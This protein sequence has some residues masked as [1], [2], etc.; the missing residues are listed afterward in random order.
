MKTP[1]RLAVVNYETLREFLSA[2]PALGYK[3]VSAM[4]AEMSQRLRQT[5]ARLVNTVYWSSSDAAATLKG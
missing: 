1:T 3:I 2:N 4:M 5:S